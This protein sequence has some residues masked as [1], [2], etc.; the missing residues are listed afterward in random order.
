MVAV[1]LIVNFNAGLEAK[2]LVFL[3]L[4]GAV[5]LTVGLIGIAHSRK[6]DLFDQ[7]LQERPRH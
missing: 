7:I 5:A 3:L 1:T 4:N 6:Q 2:E